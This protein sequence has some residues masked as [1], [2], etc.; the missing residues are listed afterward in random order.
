MTKNIVIKI[1]F[2]FKIRKNVTDIYIIEN[3][4]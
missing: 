2:N 4:R 1:N 3:L